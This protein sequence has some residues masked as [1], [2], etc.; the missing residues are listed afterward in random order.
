V[1]AVAALWLMRK[2]GGLQL[3]E[4]F[5]LKSPLDLIGALRM[6]AVFAL[7]MLVA[8]WLK[9]TWGAAGYYLVAAAAGLVDMDPITVTAARMGGEAAVAANGI[10]I[11]MAVNMMVKAALATGIGG[12]GVARAFLPATLV[13]VAAGAAAALLMP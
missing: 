8:G 3:V 6:A 7:V 4:G 10:L 5:T 9:A 11:A 1:Q 12:T 13:T 2:A